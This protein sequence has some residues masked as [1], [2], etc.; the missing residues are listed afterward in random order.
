VQQKND[1]T[2]RQG[3][4]RCGD[5]ARRA[6]AT[7]VT[8][9]PHAHANSTKSIIETMSRATPAIFF[10][11][12]ISSLPSAVVTMYRTRAQKVGRCM[13]MAACFRD[14]LV[15]AAHYV[16]EVRERRTR[17]INTT[18]PLRCQCD[19]LTWTCCCFCIPTSTMATLLIDRFFGAIRRAI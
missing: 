8:P 17:P 12:H 16:V 13:T 15:V 6:A 18:A 2:R 7:N 14:L 19:V 4:K 10:F 3:H 5:G 1:P 9:G 11:L